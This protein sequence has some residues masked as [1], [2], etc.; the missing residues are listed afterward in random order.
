MLTGESESVL[1]VGPR[2]PVSLHQSESAWNADLLRVVAPGASLA[3]S[4]SKSALKLVF[5]MV[6][7]GAESQS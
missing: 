2:P 3:D 5:T 7:E 6:Q 1:V 4:N